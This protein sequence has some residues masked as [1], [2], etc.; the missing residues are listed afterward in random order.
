[1][2][3]AHVRPSSRGFKVVQPGDRGLWITP[4]LECPSSGWLWRAMVMNRMSGAQAGRWTA[5]GW[6]GS[7]LSSA[8]LRRFSCFFHLT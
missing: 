2:A 7:R 3:S 6:R 8:H 5:V 1:M 4:D